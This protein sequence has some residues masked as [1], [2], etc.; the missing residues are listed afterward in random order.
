[1][2]G[3]IKKKN[4]SFDLAIQIGLEGS[5]LAIIL[6][7]TMYII[8]AF[9]CFFSNMIGCIGTW[10]DGTFQEINCHRHG[11]ASPLLLMTNIFR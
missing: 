10:L 3:N 4:T 2:L 9:Y 5:K 8:L 1:M 11:A 7:C 6:L